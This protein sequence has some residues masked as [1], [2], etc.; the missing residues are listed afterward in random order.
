MSEETRRNPQ[1][2]RVG[3]V[4]GQSLDTEA[5]DREKASDFANVLKDM[6]FP[7]TKEEIQQHV[8]AKSSE[9]NIGDLAGRVT[10]LRDG[11]S[12]ASVHEV[13]KDVGLVRDARK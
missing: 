10:S 12:Y 11:V 7:A 2:E 9:L 6:R 4:T 1:S 3:D 13:E 8:N 5:L